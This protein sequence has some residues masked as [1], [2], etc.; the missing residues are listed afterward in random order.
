MA[1]VLADLVRRR[2]QKLLTCYMTV[3]C[4]D[5]RFQLL[6]NTDFNFAH[7][8][9]HE[10]QIVYGHGVKPEFVQHWGLPEERLVYISMV[11]HPLSWIVSK[12]K[13]RVRYGISPWS[14]ITFD[15]CVQQGFCEF[16]YHDDFDRQGLEDTAETFEER[17]KKWIHR[18][19]VLVLVNE[20]YEGS[21]YK[22]ASFLGCSPNET[23]SMIALSK[24]PL[25][26]N[27]SSG[28][29]VELSDESLR[30]LNNSMIKDDIV[31]KL[32]T[33]ITGL[34]ESKQGLTLAALAATQPTITP[35]SGRPNMWKINVPWNWA[36]DE[37]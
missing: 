23:S 12:Y 25:N 4:D 13:H 32:V 37:E 36:D 7:D 14:N 15:Q 31:Y 11:R 26:K 20:D 9:C 21:I 8:R 29:N 22:L 35:V 24:V 17:V 5:P 19:E 18:D 1:A 28:Y 3:A 2:H 34:S 16:H 10:N 33:H 30:L 6:G 27:P